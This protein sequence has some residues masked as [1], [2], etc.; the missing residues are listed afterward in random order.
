M[1]VKKTAN[2]I[3]KVEEHVLQEKK[4]LLK[5]FEFNFLDF[6]SA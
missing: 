2:F 3:R 1:R 5:D 4:E 6:Q